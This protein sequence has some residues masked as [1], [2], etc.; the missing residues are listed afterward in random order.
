MNLQNRTTELVSQFLEGSPK[1]IVIAYSGGVDSHLLLVTVAELVSKYPAHHYLAVHVNHG[2]SPNADQWQKHCQQVCAE[3]NIQF[4]VQQVKVDAS[5]NGGLEAAARKV[6]YQALE[7]MTE[8]HG[9]ILLGQHVQ[10][11]LE[12]ILLQLKRGAGPKGLSAM[13]QSSVNE[14]SIT[15]ARPFLGLEKQDIVQLAQQKGLQWIE[16]ESNQDTRFDRNFLRSQIIPSLLERWPNLAS[17]ANR[18]AQLCAEQQQLLDE[19]NAKHLQ[20]MV[21]Q[22]FAIHIGKLQRLSEAWQNQIVRFW[23]A[24]QKV[25]MPSQSVLGE[26]PKLLGAKPD[27]NPIIDIGLYQLRRFREHLYCIKKRKPELDVKLTL[28]TSNTR[29]P[30]DLGHLHIDEK[31]IGQLLIVSRANNLK[32][33]PLGS[34]HSKLLKQWF[35]QWDVPVWERERSL[36]LYWQD[37]VIAVLCEQHITFA[38]EIPCELRT[39][40]HFRPNPPQL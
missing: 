28:T 23:L 6:R 5:A 1:Q 4:K 34:P 3:L 11:Q 17:A 31:Y 15:L 12:T 39:M 2:L 26:L 21:N 9:V 24:E 8:H 16:D 20:A 27:G 13:A 30:N 29:L 18:S 10:D 32:F 37:N 22:R 38:S 19:V 7:A 14:N 25:E 33:K 35:K 40:L 36:M